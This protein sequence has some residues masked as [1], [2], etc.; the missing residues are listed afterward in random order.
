M[1]YIP[2]MDGI[3]GV[4]FCDYIEL[5]DINDDVYIYNVFYTNEYG[6]C[7]S[8][9]DEPLIKFLHIKNSKIESYYVTGEIKKSNAEI[10]KITVDTRWLVKKQKCFTIEGFLLQY[11]DEM[12]LKYNLNPE[13]HYN[14]SPESYEGNTE[15]GK[16]R[17]KIKGNN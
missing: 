8:I 16:I 10:K 9:D 2:D 13:E 3:K 4:K 5:T 12:G 15:I 6:F 11:N 17:K 7:L 14:K 1:N